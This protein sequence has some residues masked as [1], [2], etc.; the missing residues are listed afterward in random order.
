M[1]WATGIITLARDFMSEKWYLSG[2]K[3]AEKGLC[4]GRMSREKGKRGEIEVA[5]LLQS[6][7]YNGRRGQQVKG[8]P[9]SPDV[10]GLPGVHIEVKR[11]E[12][13]GL[14]EALAQSKRDAGEDEVPVVIHRR[15]NCKWV[16]IL[17]FEEFMKLYQAGRD[18]DERH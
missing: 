8:G 14:Y 5:H 13:L 7:G 6:Y 1:T 10:R 17:E 12:K 15:N 2:A 3:F 16:V 11:T 18:K 9:D 4:M